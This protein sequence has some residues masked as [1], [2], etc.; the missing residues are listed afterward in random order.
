M[1]KT[2][3]L[4][5]VS[6]YVLAGL[7]FSM[8]VYNVFYNLGKF[9]I[10]SWDEARHGVNAYEMLKNRN[11]IV[12]TYLSHPDYW[13]LKPPLSYWAIMVGYKLVGLNALGLRLMS[14]VCA[15][16]MAI[17]IVLFMK[18]RFGRMAAIISLL[19]LSTST[20]YLLNHC[21]RTGDAD[22]LF[23]FFFTLSIISLLSA[24]RQTR[25][26]YA[27]GL[28]CSLA[29]LTKS[30]HAGNIL[31]IMAVYFLLTR[32]WGAFHWRAWWRAALSFAVPVLAWVLARYHYDG[33]RFL[34]QM[35]AYDLL[36]RSSRPIEGHIGDETYY[37]IILVHFFFWWLALLIGIMVIS[38]IQDVRLLTFDQANHRLKA[39]V[40]GILVWI[41]VPLLMFTLAKTKIRWYILPVYPP[42]C[43][44]IGICASQLWRKGTWRARGLLLAGLLFVASFY[45]MN[46]QKYIHHPKPNWELALLQQTAQMPVHGYELFM[47]HPLH[48]KD[49][50]PQNAVLTAK[51]A[52]DLKPRHGGLK[53]FL[54]TNRSLLLVKKAWFS[55]QL[56]HKYHLSVLASN[57]WGYILEKQA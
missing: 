36:L 51:L 46:I 57:R 26:L 15:I 4:R 37:G 55:K 11:F 29:F 10:S 8:M 27:A 50:W 9:P 34:K 12:N 49:H 23:V 14:G 45:E 24:R 2:G 48:R 1:R 6:F 41:C 7:I 3:Y 22:S 52:N 32:Q 20:Q 47:Y 35:I 42:L 5:N 30:W 13:N 53:T 54:H 40:V 31:L 28:A 18:K 16:F 21:A 17:V 56:E 44:L 25:W 43:M 19:A 39:D 38:Y 33:W